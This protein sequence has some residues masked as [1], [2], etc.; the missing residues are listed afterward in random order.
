MNKKSN[1]F[2]LF[3]ILILT[4]PIITLSL[5]IKDA[6][7]EELTVESDLI[8]RGKVFSSNC[9][10]DNQS[11]KKISTIIQI[12][13][14]DYLKGKEE[15]KI[16]I[17][18]M[19]GKIDDIEDIIFGTPKLNL[20]DDVLLFLVK[21]NNQYVI[22]SIAL[23]CYKIKIDNKLNELAINDLSN[24]NLVTEDSNGANKSN[25]VN[26]VFPLNDIYQEI[27]SIVN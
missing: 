1:L 18:Q 24:V 10:W 3:A 7:I 23:G 17:V 13:V 6:T 16:E 9:E 2:L 8:V 4:L 20:D 14:T 26:K 12:D 21:E 25:S 27:Q 5:T 19:G 15:K 22:H 11:L